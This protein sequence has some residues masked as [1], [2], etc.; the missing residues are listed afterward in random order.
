MLVTIINT[1]E[2]THQL[3]M[4]LGEQKSYFLY[5]DQVWVKPLAGGKR[6]PVLDL[7]VSRCI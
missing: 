1:Y 5:Q 6:V 3:L 2:L 7:K 4:S